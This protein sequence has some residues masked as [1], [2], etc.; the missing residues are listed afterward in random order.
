MAITSTDRKNELMSVIETLRNQL[1]NNGMKEG[2][3]SQNTLAISQELDKYIM[4]Y[5]R[6]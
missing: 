4:K 5:Q 6:L 3:S 2:F 1:I